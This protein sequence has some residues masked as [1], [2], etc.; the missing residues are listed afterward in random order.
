MLKLERYWPWKTVSSHPKYNSNKLFTKLTTAV[1]WHYPEKCIALNWA[2]LKPV[3]HRAFSTI[4]TFE[5][6][7]NAITPT[8]LLSRRCLISSR[9]LVSL[10]DWKIKRAGFSVFFWSSISLENNWNRPTRLLLTF[11]Y[12]FCF[13]E[14]IRFCA[15]I[16]H[17]VGDFVAQTTRII[18]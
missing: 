11:F 5:H 10:H 3:K 1:L 13:C 6:C 16:T 15:C 9:V 4:G 7:F 2:S 17:L 18:G 14:K 8:L 12:S